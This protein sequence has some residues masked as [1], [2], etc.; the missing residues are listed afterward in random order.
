NSLW[1]IRFRWS[2]WRY[3]VE[4]VEKIIGYQEAYKFSGGIFKIYKRKP[5]FVLDGFISQPKEIRQVTA[6]EYEILAE[7]VQ[8]T[9]L[10]WN[11]KTNSEVN[12]ALKYVLA[13][14]AEKLDCYPLFFDI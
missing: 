8:S 9:T 4:V 2:T 3:W 7:Y 1:L 12:K 11:D 14:F 10:K 5:A 13:P 6:D